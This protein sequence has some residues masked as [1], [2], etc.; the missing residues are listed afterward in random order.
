MQCSRS[1]LVQIS[2]DNCT[3]GSVSVDLRPHAS[4]KLPQTDKD[5]QRML[6][7]DDAVNGDSFKL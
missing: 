7:A 5:E 4:L 2:G 6:Y 1:I 3:F